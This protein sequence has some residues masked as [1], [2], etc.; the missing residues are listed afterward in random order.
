MKVTDAGERNGILRN[1]YLA[2][3]A[4]TFAYIIC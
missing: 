4:I 1:K 2:G 3:K